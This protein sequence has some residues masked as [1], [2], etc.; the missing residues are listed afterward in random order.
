MVR[1]DDLP[2]NLLKQYII[3]ENGLNDSNRLFLIK[4][5]VPI[6]HWK[7][8]KKKYTTKGIPHKYQQNN[9]LEEASN[10]IRNYIIKE[11]GITPSLKYSRRPSNFMIFLKSFL[12]RFGV[13][14]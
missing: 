11:M 13:R 1:F 14:L 12:R 2:T 5:K 9:T 7:R 8:Y 4:R 10:S 3:E 6:Y